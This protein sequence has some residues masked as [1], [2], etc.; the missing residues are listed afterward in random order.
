MCYIVKRDT[1]LIFKNIIPKSINRIREV[2]EGKRI[3]QNGFLKFYLQL[4]EY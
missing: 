3:K 2:L 4:H 1:N